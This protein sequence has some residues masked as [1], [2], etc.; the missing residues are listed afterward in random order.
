MRELD[1]GSIVICKDKEK[2]NSEA[3]IDKLRR[4]ARVNGFWY[5]REWPYKG[6]T[7]LLLA[8]PY[9]EDTS[10]AELRDYKVFCFNGIAKLM[11]VASDRQKKGESVKFDYFDMNGN[12]LDIVNN[13]PQASTPPELPQSFKI[14]IE[15]AEKI[16]MGYPHLR[17]DFYEVDGKVYFGELTLYHGSGLMSFTPDIWNYRMGEWIDI[18][19]IKRKTNVAK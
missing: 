2:F 14:M 5:G 11:L 19:S 17:V 6:V 7:P 18:N 4:G 8:E 15:L 13:H 9:L 1:S 12:H 10:T 3:A 16:S